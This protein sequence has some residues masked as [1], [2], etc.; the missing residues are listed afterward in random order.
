M[1][2]RNTALCVGESESNAELGLAVPD[3]E[4]GF[5][6]PRF[7]GWESAAGCKGGIVLG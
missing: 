7:S 4:G 3:P 5:H 2:V 1:E 6:F